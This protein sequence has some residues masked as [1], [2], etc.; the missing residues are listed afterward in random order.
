MDSRLSL[1]TASV[2]HPLESLGRFV[3]DLRWAVDIFGSISACMTPF[4]LA[5]SNVTAF[6]RAANE[7]HS[8]RDLV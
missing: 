7:R 4:S 6:L 1:P 5:L 8:P 2:S 3:K